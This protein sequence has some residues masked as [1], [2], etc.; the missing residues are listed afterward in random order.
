MF[1]TALL[2]N[3]RQGRRSAV[4]AAA[5]GTHI[6]LLAGVVLA[7]Y[8]KID[9]LP[10][11]TVIDEVLH[12][13]LETPPL[14]AA[15]APKPQQQHDSTPPAP[16]APTAP[17]V[18]QPAAVPADLPPATTDAPQSQ[19]LGPVSSAPPGTGL[20]G[21]Q[22][23]DD[24]NFS[25]GDSGPIEIGAGITPPEALT[26]VSPLYTEAAR[27]TR[28]QGPVVLEAVIDTEGNVVRVKVIKALPFGLDDNAVAAVKGWKFRPAHDQHGRAVAVYFR[29]TVY[30]H[31][32]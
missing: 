18:A 1:E 9:A 2:S 6:A 14:A 8:W 16:A 22:V 27:R 7:Q 23:G 17:A 26:R 24:V 28:V 13:G 30:Y 3:R 21:D 10:E 4:L 31:L 11:P 5:I 20:R 15:S 19:D 29:L 12:V 25:L 32:S